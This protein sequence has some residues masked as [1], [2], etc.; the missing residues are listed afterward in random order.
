MICEGFFL[1][2]SRISVVDE[3]D[4]K[5]GTMFWDGR[6]VVAKDS[7]EAQTLGVLWWITRSHTLPHFADGG[8]QDNSTIV[9]LLCQQR[10]D[11]KDVTYVT[12]KQRENT[13]THKKKQ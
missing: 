2:N 11:K 5:A 6:N 4:L 1:V 10:R 12:F 8:V 13:D 7:R 9:N 3:I